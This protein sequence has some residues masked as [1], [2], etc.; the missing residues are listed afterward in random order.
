MNAFYITIG[1]FIA[2]C[3]LGFIYCVFDYLTHDK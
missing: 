1:S 2:A 3:L